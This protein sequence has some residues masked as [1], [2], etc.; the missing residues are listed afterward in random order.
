M[1]ED[2]IVRG[3]ADRTRESYLW[4]VTGLATFY[5]R[6]PDQISDGEVQAY[7]LHLIRDRQRAWNTCHIVVHGLRFFYAHDLEAG[8]NDILHPHPAAGGEAAGDPEP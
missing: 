4:A 1:D 5:R 2:M 7:L 6:S 3:M 8:P